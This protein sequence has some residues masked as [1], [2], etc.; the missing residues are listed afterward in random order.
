MHSQMFI[1]L[2]IKDLPRSRKFF[3]SMGYAF[4]PQFS[5]EH[6]AVLRI[7]REGGR[8]GQARRHRILLVSY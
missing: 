3:E 5:N 8:I 7:A 2:P 1:N 6:G 4:N